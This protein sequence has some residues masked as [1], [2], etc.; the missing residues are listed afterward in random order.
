MFFPPAFW[1][2]QF[3]QNLTWG[4][5]N[6]KKILMES[7][8]QNLY[9]LGCFGW[10]VTYCRILSIYKLF[11]LTCIFLPKSLL[12]VIWNCWFQIPQKHY[13]RII[14]HDVSRV[15]NDLELQ[16]FD[17]FWNMYISA[18][19]EK[20][21]TNFCYGHWVFTTYGVKLSVTLLS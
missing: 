2:A 8:L 6:N 16:K 20:V 5:N 11:F 10:E 12:K 21:S 18:W 14:S 3:S 7:Y 17:K 4:F 13:I 19:K 9:I 1:R 15:L